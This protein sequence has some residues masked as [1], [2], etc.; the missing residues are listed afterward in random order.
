VR[1]AIAAIAAASFLL[2]LS[3]AIGEPESSTPG[4]EPWARCSPDAAWL[5]RVLASIGYPNAGDTGSA[6][7]VGGGGADRRAQR[8]I[9]A[10]PGGG[11][12]CGSG[13][14]WARVGKVEVCGSAVRVHWQAQGRRVW[15]EPPDRLLR[16]LVRA[17]L[18]VHRL[19]PRLVPLAARMLEHCRRSPRVRPA[20]PRLVPRVAGAYADHLARDVA[21]PFPLD[22]FNL[23]HSGEDP[24]DPRRNRPP[25]MAHLVIAAG[26]VWRLAP[27]WSL[28]TMFARLEDGAMAR[29]RSHTLALGRRTWGGH[30][31]KLYLGPPYGSNGGM[32]GNHLI[33]RWR[34]DEIDYVIS[35]HAWEP[36][37]EAE[38][39]LRRITESA[40]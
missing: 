20:C 33:F 13:D 40:G 5:R 18:R 28:G 9:W 8:F 14:H 31:G 25:R 29:T 15:F 1:A 16:P 6:L 19:P 12:G 26:D 36:L 7:V 38:L 30:T 10:T 4:C 35:L 24:G 17:S 37:S 2:G 39:V 11:S 23:E 3:A 34:S 22:V 27:V 21:R 32:L